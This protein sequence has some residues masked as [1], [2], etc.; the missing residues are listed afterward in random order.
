[1]VHEP[2]ATGCDD[3]QDSPPVPGWTVGGVADAKSAPPARARATER[4]K[5]PAAEPV[6]LAGLFQLID[7]QIQ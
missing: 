7:L 3:E 5:G 1:M 4:S 2:G 6:E